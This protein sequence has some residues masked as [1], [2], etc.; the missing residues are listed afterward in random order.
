ML[1]DVPS[2]SPAVALPD[3]GEV[4]GW[5]AGGVSGAVEVEAPPPGAELE[6]PCPV[7]EPQAARVSVRVKVKKRERVRFMGHR[8]LCHLISWLP[9]DQTWTSFAEEAVFCAMTPTRAWGI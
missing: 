7:G 4:S 1:C 5:F 6:P 2:A 3:G 8:L 9:V